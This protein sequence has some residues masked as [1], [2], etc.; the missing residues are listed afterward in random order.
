M[1]TDAARALRQLGRADEAGRLLLALAEDGKVAADGS[2]VAAQELGQ[3]GVQTKRASC[4]SAG[5]RCESGLPYVRSDA[6]QA[7]GQLG[8][9]DEAGRL[10]LALAGE[11]KWLLAVRTMWRRRW[12]GWGVRTKRAA[13]VG[14]G[15]DGKVDADV[16]SD[17]AQALGQLGH[18]DEAGGCCSRWLGDAKVA[19]DVRSDA[20][21]ASGQLGRTMKGRLLLALAGDAKAAADVRSDVAQALGSLGVRTKRAGC[22]WC[23]RAWQSRC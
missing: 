3:S 11:R 12:R 9:T 7:L 1:R 21:Q 6:A 23:G 18:A 4:R 10:L 5:R 2:S 20:A 19:A 8:R 16:R 14:A 17:A 13:V 22:C 15:E